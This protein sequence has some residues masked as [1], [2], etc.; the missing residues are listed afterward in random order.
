MTL[1]ASSLLKAR[2]LATSGTLQNPCPFPG[3]IS[4]RESF[5][6][7]IRTLN[8]LTEKE[9]Y[10]FWYGMLGVEAMN[11]LRR[12]FKGSIVSRQM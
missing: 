12:F 5:P 3:L 2:W 6:F 7:Q 1:A 9:K 10:V 4:Y 11:T 8:E